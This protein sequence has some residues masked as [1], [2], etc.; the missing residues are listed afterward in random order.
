MIWRV[1]ILANANR[2]LDNRI[3]YRVTHSLAKWTCPA[4]HGAGSTWNSG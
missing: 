1:C 2:A 4:W 3:F